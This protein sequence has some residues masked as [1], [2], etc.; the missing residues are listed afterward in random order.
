MKCRAAAVNTH[1][2]SLF[3][4]FPKNHLCII[5][6]NTLGHR[7]HVEK[8]EHRAPAAG[9]V[10]QLLFQSKSD[11]WHFTLFFLY[12]C[13]FILQA[14]ED[15]SVWICWLCSL[16]RFGLQLQMCSCC[17]CSYSIWWTG[18]PAEKLRSACSHATLCH[19]NTLQGESCSSHGGLFP[20]EMQRIRVL[21]CANMHVM[22]GCPGLVH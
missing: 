10:S 20:T 4:L 5:V 8:T 15:W 11:R 1:R 18:S 16:S 21:L 2:H 6:W 13:A 17:W 7:E 9:K 22:S 19:R 14:N 3:E 12:H